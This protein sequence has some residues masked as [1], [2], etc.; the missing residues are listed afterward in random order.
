MSAAEGE[1]FDDDADFREERHMRPADS[2]LPFDAAK[3]A[4][5]RS[6]IRSNSR[7]S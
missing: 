6:C 1:G 2:I 3:S 5:R 4:E 7:L